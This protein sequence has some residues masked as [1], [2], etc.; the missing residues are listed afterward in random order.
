MNVLNGFDEKKLDRRINSF[1]FAVYQHSISLHNASA[2]IEKSVGAF[3]ISLVIQWR[4]KDLIGNIMG[5]SF[6]NKKKCYQPKL[7]ALFVLIFEICFSFKHRYG[8]EFRNAKLVFTF[9]RLIGDS[10][11]H[12][13][14]V[15]NSFV[16]PFNKSCT[17]SYS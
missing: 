14:L 11:A 5:R 8:V 17:F 4:G 7:V 2:S 12:F 13:V 6:R 16:K 15:F 9:V 3:L 10:D 1:R